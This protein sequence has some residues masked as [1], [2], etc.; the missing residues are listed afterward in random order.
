MRGVPYIFFDCLDTVCYNI[1]YEI[2]RQMPFW[3]NR[4]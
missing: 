4:A 3:R 2:M 1:E